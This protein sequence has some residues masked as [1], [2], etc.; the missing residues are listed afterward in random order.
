MKWFEVA[1]IIL[2]LVALAIIIAEFSGVWA[3]ATVLLVILIICSFQ[4]T[5]LENLYE[6]IREQK[7]TVI[8]LFSDKIDNFSRNVEIIKNHVEQNA[9]MIESRFN[10]VQEIDKAEIDTACRELIR[11]I[12]DIE[13]SLNSVKRTLAAAYGVI[14]ERLNRVEDIL[15]IKEEKGE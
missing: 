2:Y 11:K 8:E 5:Y 1:I 10:E 13:N 3:L 7:D 9:I 14:D 6:N 12:L 4:K 15:N